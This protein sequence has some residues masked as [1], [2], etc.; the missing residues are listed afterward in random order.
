M[1]A[2]VGLAVWKPLERMELKGIISSPEESTDS[3]EKKAHQDWHHWGPEEREHL[4]TDSSGA[5]RTL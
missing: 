1:A 4:G 5:I 2:G 3:L